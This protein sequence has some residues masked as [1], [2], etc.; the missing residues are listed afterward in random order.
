[1]ATKLI[2][3]YPISDS[4][5]IPAMGRFRH[6]AAHDAHVWDGREYD[7]AKEEDMKAFNES[8]LPALSLFDDRLPK[9]VVR[10]VYEAPAVDDVLVGDDEEHV[11][12][13]QVPLEPLAKKRHAR[14]KPG[15][16]HA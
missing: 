9:S 14:L 15:F 13:L 11:S 1:M 3:V 6:V 5:S 2:I 10:A 4:R 16:A 7:T 8:I 12:H